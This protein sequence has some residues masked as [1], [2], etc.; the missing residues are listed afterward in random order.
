VAA[1]VQFNKLRN[2]LMHQGEPGVEL[3]VS[4]GDEEVRQLE[5]LVERYV[6]HRLFGDS[7]VYHT[8]YR[9]VKVQK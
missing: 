4:V 9:W 6:C 5:D 7:A 8:K 2:A 3:I 1:F